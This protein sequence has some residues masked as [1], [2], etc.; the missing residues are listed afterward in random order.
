MTKKDSLVER[1]Q[2]RQDLGFGTKLVD[3]ETRLVKKDGSF[4]IRRKG[5]SFYTWL[6]LYH[7]LIVLSWTKFIFLVLAFYI[8][9][10]IIFAI[11]YL[12]FG[13][14]NLNGITG[15][16]VNG[17]FWKAFFF[18]AQTLT[19]VGYG[20]ISPSGFSTNMLAALESLVGLM[21]FALVTGV[22]YG[23]FSRPTAKIRFSKNAVIA[24]YLDVNAFMFR[25][26]NERSHQLINVNATLVYSKI[27]EKNGISSRQYFALKLERSNVNFFPTN[28]TLVHAI[29]E[30]SPLFGETQEIMDKAD[31]EFMI[32]ISA[33]DDTFSEQVNT[34]ASYIFEEIVWGAKFTNMLNK[35]EGEDGYLLDLDKLD[36][37]EKMPLNVVQKA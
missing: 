2:N 25:I 11:F 29:T 19:T 32:S 24:P 8:T 33:L 1:E 15:E 16:M 20:H 34:R 3:R 4:N 6:N 36:D 28:W 35:I 27:V 17:D 9:I 12:L 23:R 30:E 13:I 22:L 21:I 26:V 37:F 18:S 10:N 14:E 5:Q 7:R 31:A